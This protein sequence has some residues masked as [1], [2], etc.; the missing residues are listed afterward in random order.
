MGDNA[1][2]LRKYDTLT[3]L[4]RFLLLSRVGDTEPYRAQC[5][6][7]ADRCTGL[8]GRKMELLFKCKSL[9]FAEVASI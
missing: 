5:N 1:P 7:D 6:A 4:V 3:T 8:L 2:W 9:N